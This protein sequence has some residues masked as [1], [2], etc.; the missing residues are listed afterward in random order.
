MKLSEEEIVELIEMYGR[1]LI[2]MSICDDCHGIVKT[3]LIGR[4]DRMRQFI[5]ML[6][7]DEH[8]EERHEGNVTPIKPRGKNLQ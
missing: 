8:P 1:T 3:L 5:E 2:E 4:M 6:P 7:D